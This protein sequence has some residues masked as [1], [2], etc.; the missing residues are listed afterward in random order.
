M[1]KQIVLKT[2]QDKQDN[3][4]KLVDTSSLTNSVL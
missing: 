4:T 2:H 1:L 3:F